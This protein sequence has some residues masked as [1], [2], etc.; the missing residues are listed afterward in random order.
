MD[1]E[2]N[3]FW[4]GKNVSWHMANSKSRGTGLYHGTRGAGNIRVSDL[5]YGYLLNKISVVT[6]TKYDPLV[7]PAVSLF[8]QNEC[9]GP[10]GILWAPEEYGE[11]AAY[12]K[13]DLDYLN[14]ANNENNAVKIPFGVVLEVYD[15]DVWVG[16]PT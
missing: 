16:R 4:C 1:N 15:N 6:L 11:W 14:F 7:R 13:A 9:T 5:E 10:G 2:T 3:S 12:A 8:D